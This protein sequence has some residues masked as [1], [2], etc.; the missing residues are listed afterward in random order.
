MTA[1]TLI[2]FIFAWGIAGEEGSGQRQQV[3][4]DFSFF[5]LVVFVLEQQLSKSAV[6]ANVA[7]LL[8]AWSDEALL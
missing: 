6:T 8:L 7:R 4:I 1:W 5:F 2:S 3:L